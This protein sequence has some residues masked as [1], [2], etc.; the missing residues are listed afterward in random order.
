MSVTA[1]RFI[2]TSV[3]PARAALIDVYIYAEI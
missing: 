2:T 1:T 3:S